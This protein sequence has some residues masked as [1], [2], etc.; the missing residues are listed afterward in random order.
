MGVIRG[1]LRRGKVGVDEVGVLWFDESSPIHNLG[2]AVE[3][4]SDGVMSKRGRNKTALGSLWLTHELRSTDLWSGL[5]CPPRSDLTWVGA[6]S[7]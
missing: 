5:A 1:S 4:C 7:V 2:V 3:G 6:V